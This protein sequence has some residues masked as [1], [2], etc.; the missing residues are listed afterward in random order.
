MRLCSKVILPDKTRTK[1]APGNPRDIINIS[2]AS[3]RP[4]PCCS[5]VFGVSGKRLVV[6]EDEEEG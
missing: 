1:G 3:R 5:D 6:V 4:S 2:K